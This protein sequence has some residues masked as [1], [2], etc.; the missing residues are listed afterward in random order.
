[1]T[2]N[3]YQRLA[4]VRKA[5][6]FIKKEFN[7]K[8]GYAAVKS[9][10]AVEVVREAINDNGLI[11]IPAMKESLTDSV[12][13]KTKYGEQ[14]LYK[15]K[16]FL[17]YKWINIDD[18]KDE[19]LVPWSCEAWNDDP[20]KAY[21]AALTYAEK[22]FITKQ[23]NIPSD[24]HDPDVNYL[25]EPKDNNKP[26]DTSKLTESKEVKEKP[27]N[28]KN[29]PISEKND[30][31]DPYVIHKIAFKNALR[32]DNYSMFVI[33]LRDFAIKEPELMNDFKYLELTLH[34]ARNFGK[35]LYIDIVAELIKI[36]DKLG[37][38]LKFDELI[39]KYSPEKK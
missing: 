37:G 23:F 39:K 24:E 8:L 5:C 18:P 11:L 29:N 2:K 21:G 4:E 9:S 14:T 38:D 32:V 17:D 3:V 16:I 20:A 7:P 13:R 25:P 35:D 1:M 28:N 26:K 22:Y 15:V 27:D 36:K 33:A 31:T 19:V 12:I 34:Y 6:N 30:T 10:Q